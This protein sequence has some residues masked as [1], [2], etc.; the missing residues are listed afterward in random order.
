MGGLTR[1]KSRAIGEG[2]GVEE[3]GGKGEEAGAREAV[4][5]DGEEG[6]DAGLKGGGKGL[7]EDGRRG[8]RRGNGREE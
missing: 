4:V 5:V 1:P 8:T 2:G 3:V 7:E 6:E